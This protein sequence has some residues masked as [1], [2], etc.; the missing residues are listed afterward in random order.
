M[1]NDSSYAGF[2]NFI[3]QHHQGER[4]DVNRRMFSVFLW[5]F[6][7]PAAVSLLII[8]LV[9]LG[10]L[11]RSMRGYLDWIMLVFPVLYSVYFLS[12]QVI[13]GIPMAFRQGGFAMTVT[14]A[15][16]D[17]EWRGKVVENLER[18]LHYTQAQW[19]WVVD[20]LEEDLLRIQLKSRHITALAGA[21]FFLLMQ[22]I[23]SITSDVADTVAAAAADSGAGASSQWMGLLLFLV[24]LYLSGQQSYYNLRRYLACAKWMRDYRTS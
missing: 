15:R 10:V 7:A 17:S 12:S 18:D 22:G 11:P 9:N 23:D 4:W 2:L 5:C 20:N 16:I 19:R 6:F 21:V 24:L 1:P 14:Q 8:V 13:S 3:R